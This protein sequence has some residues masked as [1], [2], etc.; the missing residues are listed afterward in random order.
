MDN[1]RMYQHVQLTSWHDAIGFC[2]EDEDA[3]KI[4]HEDFM[5]RLITKF[6]P[7]CFFCNLKGHFRS[8]FTQIWDAVADIKHHRHD[9]AL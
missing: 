2:L 5:R 9:E 7:R 1:R 6:G 4:D 8:D 3:S